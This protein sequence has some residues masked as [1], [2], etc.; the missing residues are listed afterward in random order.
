MLHTGAEHDRRQLPAAWVR[1]ASCF[2]VGALLAVVLVSVLSS[3]AQLVGPA[4]PD[5]PMIT[6]DYQ[7]HID[8]M[9]VTTPIVLGDTL[10]VWLWG[11]IGTEGSNECYGFNGIGSFMES[12]SLLTLAAVGWQGS[13]PCCPDDTLAYLDGA[14]YAYV[15]TVA[16]HITVILYNHAGSD[17]VDTV[18]VLA[19]EPEASRARSN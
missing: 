19:R 7:L 3:C 2:L 14:E 6:T 17:L 18:R 16:G 13:G 12:D 10:R 11:P 8:S 9:R 5:C 15:P 1:A 4:G